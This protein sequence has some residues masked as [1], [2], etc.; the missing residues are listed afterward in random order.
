MKTRKG[1]QFV[2]ELIKKDSLPRK[3]LKWVRGS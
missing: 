3:Y 2:L 1:G